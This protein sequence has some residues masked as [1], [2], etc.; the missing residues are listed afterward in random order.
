VLFGLRARCALF[1]VLAEGPQSVSAL[2]HRA[3]TAATTP[4]TPARRRGLAAACSS[5][6]ATAATGS[7]SWARRW[8]ATAPWRR[9]SSTTP[10]LYLDLADPVALLRGD[11]PGPALAA[12]LGLCRRPSSAGRAP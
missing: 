4:P 3:R 9:W 11:A 5:A 10:S 7:V 8:S 6:A 1:E 2:A 12:L